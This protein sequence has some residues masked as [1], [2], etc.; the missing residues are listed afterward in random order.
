MIYEKDALLEFETKGTEKSRYFVP[1]VFLSASYI[2]F[3]LLALLFDLNHGFR[4]VKNFSF[5]LIF[6]V[7]SLPVTGVILLVKKNKF[8]WAICLFY[9]LLIM[10][11]L[12]TINLVTFLK[13]EY[14]N[15]DLTYGWQAVI[16]FLTTLFIILMLISKDVRHYLKISTPDLGATLVLSSVLSLIIIVT[17]L[18]S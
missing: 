17:I 9:N 12:L 1:L 7:L 2:L 6:I 18:E 11:I 8:G 5:E 10:L 16:I 4:V 14:F 15:F 3:I 13:K